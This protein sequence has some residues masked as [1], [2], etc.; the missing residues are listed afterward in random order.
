[1]SKLVQYIRDEKN[2]PFGVVVA[3]VVDGEVR[4]G[5]SVCNKKDKFNKKLAL[6]I[7]VG[8]AT[9]GCDTYAPIRMVRRVVMLPVKMDGTE[10]VPHVI[11]V[12]AVQEMINIMTSR[13][14]RYFRVDVPYELTYTKENI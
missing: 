7:A 5:V 11:K 8:R 6:E 3:L 13:A 2:Q 10:L 4:L 12:D 14:N 1:M 9:V